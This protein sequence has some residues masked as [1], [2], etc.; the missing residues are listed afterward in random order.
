MSK[1]RVK[2]LHDDDDDDNG[3][4]S[5]PL[6]NTYYVLGY[7]VNIL[8]TLSLS[9]GNAYIGDARSMETEAQGA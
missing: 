7:V 8:Y 2:L 4:D 3:G 1:I 6:L 9:F 5:R